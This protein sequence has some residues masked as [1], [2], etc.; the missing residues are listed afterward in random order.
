MVPSI[1]L[2]TKMVPRI[3]LSNKNGAKDFLTD[4]NGAKD[5]FSTKKIMNH[6]WEWMMKHVWMS[7]EV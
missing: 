4:K 3:S 6:D 7:T 1:S 2:V 5:F